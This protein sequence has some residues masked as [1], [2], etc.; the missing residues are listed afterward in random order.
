MTNTRRKP[1]KRRFTVVIS[2]AGGYAAYRVRAASASLAGDL[3]RQAHK[4]EYPDDPPHD[5]GC[6][7][8]VAGWPSMWV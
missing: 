6:A 7:A 2:G 5:I 4:E 3:G 8:V 1:S